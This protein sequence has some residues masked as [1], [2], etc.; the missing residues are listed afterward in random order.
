MNT[1]FDLDNPPRKSTRQIVS[2]LK[3]S[4]QDTATHI[5]N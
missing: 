2:E 4:G 1:L 3:E 5:S